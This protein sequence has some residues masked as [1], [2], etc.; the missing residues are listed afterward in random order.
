[1]IASEYL[2]SEKDVISCDDDDPLLPFNIA[3]LWEAF[4]TIYS[5]QTAGNRIIQWDDS[6]MISV[7]KRVYFEEYFNLQEEC[8]NPV[9]V[10]TRNYLD[11]ALAYNKHYFSIAKRQIDFMEINDSVAEFF[12]KNIG[13]LETILTSETGQEVFPG[14]FEEYAS[15]LVD[16]PQERN[17]NWGFLNYVYDI[18]GQG[19]LNNKTEAIISDAAIKVTQ[20]FDIKEHLLVFKKRSTGIDGGLLSLLYRRNSRQEAEPVEYEAVS[21]KADEL[22]RQKY[23]LPTFYTYIEN[24]QNMSRKKISEFKKRLGEEIGRTVFEYYK[25][26]SDNDS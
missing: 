24:S 8:D 15:L 16:M 26:R 6:W 11:E 18:I 20:E 17:D 19:E 25:S 22:E 21:V 3:G 10:L 1:M 5:N 7:L 14:V 2:C 9:K 4:D 23:R 12:H 13:E